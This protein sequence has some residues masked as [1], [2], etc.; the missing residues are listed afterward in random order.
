MYN[1]QKNPEELS[2]TK[3]MSTPDQQI[4]QDEEI[5]KRCKN[6]PKVIAR[7]TNKLTYKEDE[8]HSEDWHGQK[9]VRIYT[10]C[11]SNETEETSHQPNPNKVRRIR[12]DAPLI[13]QFIPINQNDDNYCTCKDNHCEVKTKKGIERVN[14][15][16]TNPV[17]SPTKEIQHEPSI[18]GFILN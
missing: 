18:R 16:T 12:K 17:N 2:S 7:I 3:D 14:K 6:L 5:K 13:Y 11:S 15:V 1:V 4:T 10:P 8:L 9:Q